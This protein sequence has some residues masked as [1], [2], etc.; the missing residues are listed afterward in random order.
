MH[1]CRRVMQREKKKSCDLRLGAFPFLSF[2]FCERSSSVRRF[3]FFSLRL[4]PQGERCRS[5]AVLSCVTSFF[6]LF[7][8]S[9]D[10]NHCAW[11]LLNYKHFFFVCVCVCRLHGACWL[12]FLFRRA[13][14]LFYKIRFLVHSIS[15]TSVLSLRNSSAYYLLQKRRHASWRPSHQYTNTYIE[16]KAL[17]ADPLLVR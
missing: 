17:W 9:T 1:L 16:T 5:T 6:P 10:D 2:R 15:L 4:K 8:F 11:G 14:R 12:F 3:F 13:F 7:Q